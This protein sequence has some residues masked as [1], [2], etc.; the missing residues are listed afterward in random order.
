MVTYRYKTDLLIIEEKANNN[1]KEFIFK[2]KDVDTIV[3]ALRKVR[4][5]FDSD[6]IYTDVI[7]YS[8]PNH[9]YQ[10]IVR[11]NYYIDFLLVLFKNK[12]IQCIEWK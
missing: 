1:D 9:E 2:V 3:P 8:H 10:V 5:F 7:F 11:Q 12:I 6:K 4:M